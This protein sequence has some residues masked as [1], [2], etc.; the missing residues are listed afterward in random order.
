MK[1]LHFRHFNTNSKKFFKTVIFFAEKSKNGSQ[2]VND[3]EFTA[4]F[5]LILDFSEDFRRL[6]TIP[7]DCRRFPKTNEEV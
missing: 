2:K 7:E 6:P 5:T 4:I 1:Q 3:K